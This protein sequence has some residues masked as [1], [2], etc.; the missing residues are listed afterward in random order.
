MVRK[1]QE[2]LELNNSVI[3]VQRHDRNRSI[4]CIDSGSILGASWVKNK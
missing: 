2:K 3:L 4:Y 1:D